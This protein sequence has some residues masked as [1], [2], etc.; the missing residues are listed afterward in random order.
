M[1]QTGMKRSLQSGVKKDESKSQCVASFDHT[2]RGAL[3]PPHTSTAEAP[4]FEIQNH[5]QACEIRL[6]SWQLYENLR[7]NIF[8]YYFG[9]HTKKKISIVRKHT[10]KLYEKKCLF[11][12]N[13]VRKKLRKIRKST[14]TLFENIREKKCFLRSNWFENQYTKFFSSNWFENIRKL[15]FELVRKY[16]IFS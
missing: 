13:L 5:A 4:W 1:V 8:S 11:Y 10:K 14:K 6:E 12:E 7:K 15:E 16:I 3:S 9:W 2:V